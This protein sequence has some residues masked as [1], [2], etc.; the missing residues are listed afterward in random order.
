MFEIL[1]RSYDLFND[2]IKI[3]S[4]LKKIPAFLSPMSKCKTGH[5]FS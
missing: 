1:D 4:V 3:G 5:L 2:L